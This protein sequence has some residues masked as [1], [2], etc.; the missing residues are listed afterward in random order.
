MNQP[1]SMAHKVLPLASNTPGARYGALS[2]TDSSGNFWLFGGFG[3]SDLWKFNPTT[4]MWTWVSGSDTTGVAGSYG[5]M[6]A[7][8]PSNAPGNRAYSSGWIDSKGNLWMYGGSCTVGTTSGDLADL[9]E[10]NPASNQWTWVAGN[11]LCGTQ[12]PVYGTEGTPSAQNTPGATAGG[13]AWIDSSDNLWLFGD[14]TGTGPGVISGT[15]I[16]WEFN[17]KTSQWVWVSGTNTVDATGNF[18]TMGVPSA[19]NAPPGRADA[20][21][22]TDKSGNFWMFGGW[23]FATNEG[24]D[25]QRNDLWRYQP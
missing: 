5:T 2:W 13:G 8:S 21:S 25:A 4:E 16:L 10:Y 18:G 12:S 11:N 7:A 22:W 24:P 3:Y 14:I 15:N 6:G 20:A 19:T 1:E 9:W 23:S 17:P